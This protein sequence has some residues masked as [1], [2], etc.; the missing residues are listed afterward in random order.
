MRILVDTS[1]WSLAFRRGGTRNPA[2]TEAVAELEQL[3]D[4]GRAFLAGCIR[5]ELLSGVPHAKD[6]ERL[7]HALAP[8]E[9]LEARR[10]HHELAAELFNTCRARG[11]QGSH[12][13]FLICALSIAN[14]APVFTTDNDFERYATVLDLPL[15]A[16]R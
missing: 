10:A 14:A 11:I 3:V 16:P 12:I 7:R 1:V 13:D 4:E 8:F 2:Q 15:H 9:D 6:F 5:Q